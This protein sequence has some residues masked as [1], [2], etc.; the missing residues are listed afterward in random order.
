MGVPHGTSSYHPIFT[1][2]IFHEINHPGFLGYPHDYGKPY[3]YSSTTLPRNGRC[4]TIFRRPPWRFWRRSVG[5]WCPSIAWKPCRSFGQLWL[6]DSPNDHPLE[7]WD[8]FS[9]AKKKTAYLVWGCSEV[10]SCRDFRERTW[11]LQRPAASQIRW[12]PAARPPKWRI[13]G[14]RPCPMY[15]SP[16]TVPSYI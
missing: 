4:V 8:S 2:R 7:T 3:D 15:G 6:D 11:S 13:R 5:P 9:P 1:D 16:L 12:R 10:V 14:W